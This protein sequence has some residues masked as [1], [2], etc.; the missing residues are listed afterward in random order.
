[1]ETAPAF[2]MAIL[3]CS[4]AR[5]SLTDGGWSM[6]VSAEEDFTEGFFFPYRCVISRGEAEST[7][8]KTDQ[9]F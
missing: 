4:M 5:R 9:C 1:M 8:R 2:D 7:R 3:L 6:G